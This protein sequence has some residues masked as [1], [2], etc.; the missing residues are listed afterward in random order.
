MTQI[1]SFWRSTG[2]LAALLL[3]L[4][5]TN[6]SAGTIY[7][8]TN[9][10]SNVPGLA[11]TTDPNLI[12]PWGV[13]F[14]PKSPFWVSDQGTNLATLY[15]GAGNIKSLVVSVGPTPG[16]TGQVFN[17]TSSFGLPDGSP[18]V[19]L[20]STLAGT[21]DA[22]NPGIIPITTSITV[23]TTP[24]AVYTGLA[25]GSV[26]M[27]NY[28]YAADV[29]G[30]INVFDTNFT[31]VT[32]TT[33][34]GK[35]VDPSP[36]AGFTPFGIQ[37]IN[38]NLFVMYAQLKGVIGQPGGFVD[39]FD[40]SGNF[41]KRIATNGPLFAPWGI[42]MAPSRFGQFS[43]DLLIGQFGNGE[44]LAYDPVTDAFLGTLNGKNGMP[45]VNDFLWSLEFRTAGPMIS[46][47]ALY[48]TAGIDN[49]MGGLFGEIAPAP[50]PGT[51]TLLIAAA[52]SLAG[53]TLWRLKRNL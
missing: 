38:G 25:N 36:V 6:L 7:V 10:V 37:N 11:P 16:P 17:G 8:Q 13:S 51:I 1:Y 29:T 23:A 18:A 28:L 50:E 12:N 45:I 3:C 24:G 44:I 52:S 34:A 35:F 32:S 33:F 19:F 21:L 15:D 30:H 9:L 31:N 47:N 22:W 14:A 2:M 46:T 53:R 41:I 43:G 26:G 27:A 42:T 49:Q 39:E 4:L 48:F 20:F 5:C 40:T